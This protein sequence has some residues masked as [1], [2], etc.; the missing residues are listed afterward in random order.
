[1]E[2]D[3]PI[4]P[5]YLDMLAANYRAGMRLVDFHA[6]DVAKK[7]NR[8]VSEETDGRIKNIVNTINGPLVL[9]NAI[10][11]YGEW[12]RPFDEELT[13][14]EPFY[15]LD[16]RTVNAPL[17][18]Q[19]EFFDYTEGERFQAIGLPYSNSDLAMVILLPGKGQFGEI[20]SR[21]TNDWVQGILQ[22]FQNE[23]VILVMPKFHFETPAIRLKETLSA[24]GMSS[25]FSPEAD[26]SGITQQEPGL[27]IDEVLHKAFIEV[28]EKGTEAA[29]ASVVLMTESAPDPTRPPLIEMRIDRPFIFLIRDRSTGAIL[30]VGRVI[31]PTQ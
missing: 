18:H 13:Q 7:I 30:F 21:F 14:S 16:G 28:N 31:D 24:M 11:F 9:A 3:Y 5:E 25:A 17:M 1:M 4:I 27:A 8:W 22:G 20:E 12:L 19:Q 2:K 15:L 29:A 23:E 6:D 10:Y 26:F